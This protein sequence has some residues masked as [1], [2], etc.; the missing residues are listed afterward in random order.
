MSIERTDTALCT[1]C[2]LCIDSIDQMDLNPVFIYEKELCIL[3]A[4]LI[5]RRPP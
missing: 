1:G 3:D 5:L 4:K 2:R